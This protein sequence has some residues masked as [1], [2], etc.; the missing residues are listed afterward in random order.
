MDSA[1]GGYRPSGYPPDRSD[2]GVVSR[3][4]LV[5]FVVVFVIVVIPVVSGK[6]L[7]VGPFASEASWPKYA[8]SGEPTRRTTEE[9]ESFSSEGEDAPSAQGSSSSDRDPKVSEPEVLIPALTPGWQGLRSSR[10]PVAY[11]VPSDWVARSSGTIVGYEEPDPSAP[12]GY[13][14]R[15]AMSGVADAPNM[16]C[17]AESV[18]RARFGSNGS[19]TD[20]ETSALASAVATEWANAAYEHGGADPLLR[21]TPPRPF[22]SHGMRGHVVL[23]EVTPPSGSCIDKAHVRVASLAVSSGSDIYNFIYLGSASGDTAIDPA[24]ID[25]IFSTIREHGS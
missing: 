14:P 25:T 22:V 23:I 2:A 12:L 3:V 6:R 11:D 9:P 10:R 16:T 19:G 17:G 13:R 7:G 18:P 1:A 5:L 21:A 24:T 4:A 8:A 20:A 15:V